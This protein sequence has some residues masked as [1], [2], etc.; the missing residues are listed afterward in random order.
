PIWKIVAGHHPIHSYGKHSR[1]AGDSGPM[2]AIAGAL[3][4]AHVDLYLSGHDHNQQLIVRDGEPVY[5]INGAGGGGLYKMRGQ[6]PDL[7]VDREGYGFASVQADAKTLA[8][9]FF[10]VAPRSIARYTLS[11]ACAAAPANCLEAAPRP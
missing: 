2:A 5:L 6:S 11:R 9:E 7:R 10:D 1:A 3:I 4:A 8:I